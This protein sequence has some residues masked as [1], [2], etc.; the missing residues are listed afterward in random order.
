MT[1]SADSLHRAEAALASY[2][3][4]LGTLAARGVRVAQ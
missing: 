1:A 3:K 4:H 2:D